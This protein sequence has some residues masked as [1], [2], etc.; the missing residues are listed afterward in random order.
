MFQNLPPLKSLLAFEAA[1]RF[2]SFSDAANELSL[3]QGA[4]SYQV[5]QLEQ[6]LGIKLFH[7]SVRQVELESRRKTFI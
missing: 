4:I 3:T 5:K 7:R 1:A 6:S 2:Q